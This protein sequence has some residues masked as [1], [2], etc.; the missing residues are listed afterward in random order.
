MLQHEMPLAA[1]AV[2]H[3]ARRVVQHRGIAGPA[4]DDDRLCLRHVL[5]D[6]FGQQQAAG[7]MLVLGVAVAAVRRR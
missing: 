5:V 4:L 6:A 1:V 3:D 2:N 7:A